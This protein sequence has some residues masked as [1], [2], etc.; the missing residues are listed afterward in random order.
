[1]PTGET[2]GLAFSIG[3]VSICRMYIITLRICVA[4]VG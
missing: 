1:M 3:G 4:A 2:V